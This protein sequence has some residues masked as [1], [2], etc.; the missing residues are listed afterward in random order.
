MGQTVYFKDS[1]YPVTAKATVADVLCFEDLD[2]SKIDEI[3]RIYGRRIGASL[4]AAKGLL[5]KKYCILIFL[6]DV[7]AIPPFAIDKAGFGNMAAW[8]CVKNIASIRKDI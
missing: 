7:A 8:I 2:G 5:G 6:E 4:D 1:G 3:L